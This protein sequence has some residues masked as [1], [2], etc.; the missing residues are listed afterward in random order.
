M[1][2]SLL[3]GKS[4]NN[5]WSILNDLFSTI[6]C[7]F[8]LTHQCVLQR[9]E[10]NNLSVWLC[11]TPV[12]SNHFNLSA[13]EFWDALAIKYRKS[14]LNLPP[15]CDGLG[16][17]FSLDHFLICR[18]GGLLSSITMKSGM[19]WWLGG[20]CNVKPWLL[21]L[22]ISMVRP[23]LLICVFTGF[24]CHRLR[25]CL[26]Y[27]LLILAPN[28]IFALLLAEL[29]WMQKLKRRLIMHKLV[30][31]DTLIL[32]PL[33]FSVD[34]LVGSEASYFW[35]RWHAGWILSGTEVM[36]RCCGGF[37]PDW[38]LRLYRLQCCVCVI[39]ASNGEVWALRMVLPLITPLTYYCYCSLFLCW[40]ASMLFVCVTV[41][42]CCVWQ[43]IYIIIRT[44][45]LPIW[46]SWFHQN[47]K[48]LQVIY[49][50]W[51]N[52]MNVGAL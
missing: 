33:C 44:T 50:W 16:A 32:H 24:G 51:P 47:G 11:V 17:T 23:L 19:L 31:L 26:I 12:E 45:Y 5:L 10:D 22:R 40:P 3:L 2:R 42:Y 20:K 49:N 27:V 21:R 52:R 43:E 25:H 9:A 46:I 39:P 18:R 41:V 14:L 48:Q 38:L 35:R 8:D 37:M 4:T 36:L 1:I 13:Q 30:L 6:S 28:H 15:K 29:C 7:N 34:G